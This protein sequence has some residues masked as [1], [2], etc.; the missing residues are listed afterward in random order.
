MTAHNPIDQTRPDAPE[1]AAFGD[2]VIGVRTL[3]FT[4]ADQIDILNVTDA[5]TPTYDRPLTVEVWYPAADG[6]VPGT[7]YDTVIR[8]GRTATTLSGRAARDAAPAAGQTFPLVI[9]SHGYPGNRFLLSHLGENLASK[10]YVV[11]SI[12]HTDSTYSDQ[13]AF[14]STLLN[15]PRDQRF[16]L[17]QM[18]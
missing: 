2:Q 18:A 16:V 12:D 5:A 10:G 13:A 17:D 15:R 3:T 4:H 7:T 11:A 14:G 9:I 6:T 8:D 1:L